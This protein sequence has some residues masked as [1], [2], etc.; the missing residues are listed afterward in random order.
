MML[1]LSRR[2]TCHAAV[3]QME[4]SVEIDGTSFLDD[5]VSY[6]WGLGDSSDKTR[7]AMGDKEKVELRISH[8]SF[9]RI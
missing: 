1:Y 6:S 8:D 9:Q 5:E 3:G 7:A 2:G 4:V